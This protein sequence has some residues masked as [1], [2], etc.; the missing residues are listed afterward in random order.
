MSQTKNLTLISTFI[1]SAALLG[2]NNN[3]DPV[4]D[5]MEPQ[6]SDVTEMGDTQ[7]ETDSLQD[8]ARADTAMAQTPVSSDMSDNLVLTK[9]GYGSYIIGDT[10]A[11]TG[12]VLGTN[13]P[14]QGNCLY[15]TNGEDRDVLFMLIDEKL[16]R[17]D[18]MEGDLSM[19]TGVGLGSSGDDVKSAYAGKLVVTPGKYEPTLEDYT[20]TFSETRGAVF[21]VQNDKVQNY[22]VGQFPQ[23]GWVEG[24]L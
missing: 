21:Q 14:E 13:V 4:P 9:D 15:A 19:P 11:E 10:L 22:R 8:M 3:S 5:P 17:I 23:V 1:L 6:T 7:M 2:C 12:L 24:C 18:V 20:V 16:A